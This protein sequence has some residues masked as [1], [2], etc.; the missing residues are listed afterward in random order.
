MRIAF[1]SADSR[2]AS[3]DGPW[4]R[5]GS[6][7]WRCEIPAR[8]LRANGHD[9]VHVPSVRRRPTGELVPVTW[10]G[11]EDTSGYDVLV[12]LRWMQDGAADAIRAARTTGQTVVNDCDDWFD[13]IHGS[14]DAL[15]PVAGSD[16]GPDL[17]GYRAS[18][19]ASSALTA[20]TPYLAERL[21]ALGRPVLVVRN[22]IDL[23]RWRVR[24]PP[25]TPVVVG[26]VGATGW[27]PGDLETL[28]A[29][30]GP[31]LRRHGFR[32]A[33]HGHAGGAPSAADLLA[34]GADQ[35]ERVRDMVAAEQ[36]PELFTGIHIGLVPLHTAPFNL[37]KC[38][39]VQVPVPTPQGPVP[40]AELR[41]GQL[42]WNGENWV[43]VEAVAHELPRAGLRIRTVGGRELALTPE[44]RMRTPDGWVP[45][46]SLAA[47]DLLCAP[48]AP[49][50]GAAD[51]A[52][53]VGPGEDV[54]ASVRPDTVRPVDIQVTG[55]VFV[56]AGLVSHNSAV[57]GMEYAASGIPFVA[58]ATG[59]YEWFAPDVTAATDRDWVDQLERLSDPGER[60]ATAVRL[61]ARVE[62][63]DAAI[64]W[65]DWEEALR[66]VVG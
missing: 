3:P 64:R 54:I 33:H 11:E 35:V 63:L 66:A 39:D 18:L 14:N 31:Y 21:E 55:E 53:G 34:V 49:H 6:S 1:V 16:A 38:L 23:A 42:V 9:A 40:V 50:N 26:W 58:Q 27:H 46:G 8:Y 25:S 47:G 13:G 43:A 62:E 44:H 2:R 4:L 48:P 19:A 32:F 28:S 7:W 59:E 56:A 51:D 30:V 20:S 10:E 17:H 12:L 60:A 37:A 45:G 15:R 29:V 41:P 22:A 61:R 36:Y 24:P 52:A 57:K 65:R 5:S